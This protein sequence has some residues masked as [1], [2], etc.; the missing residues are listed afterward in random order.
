VG[1]VLWAFLERAS[2]GLE[3]EGYDKEIV[4]VIQGVIVLAVVIAYELVRRYGLV[5][6]QRQVG[7][8]LAAAAGPPGSGD[9]HRN[10]GPDDKQEVKA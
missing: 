6:Q 10:D 9:N 5:R 1:A 8:E 3:F 7:E 4:G 2:N